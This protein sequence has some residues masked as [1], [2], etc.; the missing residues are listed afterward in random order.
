MSIAPF[1]LFFCFNVLFCT[2]VWSASNVVMV[3]GEEWRGSAIH[4]Q[5]Q[6][7]FKRSFTR[8]CLIRLREFKT[9][10]S[11]PGNLRSLTHRIV[12]DLRSHLVDRRTKNVQEKWNDFLWGTQHGNL[13]AIIRSQGGHRRCKNY[14]LFILYQAEGRILYL[15]SYLIISYNFHSIMCG[16]RPSQFLTS[17]WE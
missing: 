4:R 10:E 12:R 2:G 11:T 16:A 3:S 6:L 15:I 1:L 17:S 13:T 14:K 9:T 7:L 5:P 8:W